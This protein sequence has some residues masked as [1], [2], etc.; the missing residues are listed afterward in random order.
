MPT[1]T[2]KK[3]RA[4]RLRKHLSRIPD[5]DHRRSSR[6][7]FRQSPSDAW[8]YQM[9]LLPTRWRSDAPSRAIARTR[10][11]R[12][13][14]QRPTDPSPVE[15]CECCD[16]PVIAVG[17]WGSRRLFQW[18]NGIVVPGRWMTL[19]RSCASRWFS[20]ETANSILGRWIPL[21]IRALGGQPPPART[22][23]NDRCCLRHPTPSSAGYQTCWHSLCFVPRMWKTRKPR[24]QEPDQAEAESRASGGF[25]SW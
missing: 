25:Q 5:L 7:M 24:E 20:R 9:L 10:P 16:H 14:R 4:G 17:G 13:R 1:P 2:P 6:G 22:T 23:R 18:R 8:S 19:R 21:P 11:I 15:G 12:C 3:N